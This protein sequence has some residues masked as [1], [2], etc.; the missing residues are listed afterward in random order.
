MPEA[1]SREKHGAESIGAARRLHKMG[2]QVVAL[3][4]ATPE[5]SVPTAA[6]RLGG[7]LATLSGQR[8][9]IVDPSAR[10]PVE[11]LGK[12]PAVAAADDE[13]PIF[14]SSWIGSQ[15]VVLR[16]RQ[17]PGADAGT[18]LLS[19]LLAHGKRPF[20]HLL[21]DLSGLDALGEHVAAV[22][23]VDAVV[24]VAQA[25]RT[26]QKDLVEQRRELPVEKLL[27]VLILD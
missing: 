2:L 21:V 5:V 6:V 10:W 3:L 27:G 1:E 15:L 25:G 19:R 16:P 17:T 12:E 14:S 18:A 24:L 23:L 8:I 7:A 26:R 11:L 9:G 4:G 22:E 13:A 20:A